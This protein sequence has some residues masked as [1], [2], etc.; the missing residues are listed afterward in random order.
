M[1]TEEVKEL[2][3]F[4]PDQD[5]DMKEIKAMSD[6]ELM[7]HI[8]ND[9]F[10]PNKAG[11]NIMKATLDDMPAADI[12][13]LYDL[14]L[15]TKNNPSFN[16]IPELPKKIYDV[17]DSSEFWRGTAKKEFRSD[18]NITFRLATEELEKKF[19]DEA[20][21]LGMSSLK[22]HRSVGGI[23]ATVYNAF[24][25]EGVDALVKFMKEFEARNG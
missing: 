10:V 19:L 20:K 5:P 25:M 15:K 18:M 11:D 2:D 17:I 21:A 22:G 12:M 1:S 14:A 13:K 4:N 16:P 8:Q 23:R 9:E 6:Q 7:D 3:E 24:P